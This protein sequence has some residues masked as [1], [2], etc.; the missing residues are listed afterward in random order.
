M[1]RTERP[2]AALELARRPASPRRIAIEAVA[3]TDRGAK[4]NAVLARALEEAG[5]DERDRAFVTEVVYGTVRM[6]RACDWLVGEFARRELEP[7]LKAAARVGAY[8]LAFMRVPAYAAVSATVAEAPRR[9]RPLLNAVL[10]RVAERLEGGEAPWPDLATK[11][12][13]PDWLV[14]RLSQDL[15]RD[16]ALAA[17]EQMNQAARITLRED[18]YPQGEASQAVARAVAELLAEATAG[19]VLDACSAPGGKASLLAAQA[20]LVVAAEVVPERVRLLSGHVRALGL[21]NVATVLADS[22]APPFREKA[23]AAVLVD[24]PCSGLG[25]LHRRPDA[26]WKL[27][28]EDIGRLAALQRRLLAAAAP[29]VA[30]GGLLVYSVC[31]LSLAETEEVDRWLSAWPGWRACRVRHSPWEPLGRGA[32]LLPQPGGADGMFVLALRREG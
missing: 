9:A 23:F 30:P 3:A 32:R 11:L 31:T 17:L 22:T 14:E 5:L 13:Y 27:R 2:S 12:S 19:P 1:R 25:V 15:G 10:R 29:L 6:R 18:G 21:A 4:A 16:K 20:P 7:G 24:A 8:Q 28:P 26:R